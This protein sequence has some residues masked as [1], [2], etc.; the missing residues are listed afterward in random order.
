M[1]WSLADWSWLVYVVCTALLI[2]GAIGL[3]STVRNVK[4]PGPP[5]GKV[6]SRGRP[7]RRP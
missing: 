2:A 7:R 6:T 4:L 1:T 5:E 3:A